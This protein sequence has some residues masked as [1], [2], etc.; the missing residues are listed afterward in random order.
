MSGLTPQSPSLTIHP[1]NDPFLADFILE[2]AQGTPAPVTV[3]QN[4]GTAVT[5]LTT[6]VERDTVLISI[7]GSDADV[8]DTYTLTGQPTQGTATLEVIPAAA[9]ESQEYAAELPAMGAALEAEFMAEGTLD[10]V[11][12]SMNWNETPDVVP[13]N[14]SLS[15]IAP[16]GTTT[17]LGGPQVG[18][19]TSG[20]H[21][22]DRIDQP[23]ADLPAG[24]RRAEYS[25]GLR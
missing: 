18:T 23:C 11:T 25:L 17:K 1:V 3:T 12:V 8:L 2:G 10:S 21:H 22:H 19:S 13:A 9:L 7:A 6:A 5:F 24:P 15:L 4:G 20:L 14:L 16:D